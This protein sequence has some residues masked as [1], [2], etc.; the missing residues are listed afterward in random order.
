MCL[1]LRP[2]RLGTVEPHSS[3]TALWPCLHPE[4][5]DL[6]VSSHTHP[7]PDFHQS[8]DLRQNI[9]LQRASP[10]LAANSRKAELCLYS[11]DAELSPGREGKMCA[12]SPRLPGHCLCDCHLVLRNHY[13]ILW[14]KNLRFRQNKTGAEILGLLGVPPLVDLE[15][16]INPSVPTVSPHRKPQWTLAK[17]LDLCICQ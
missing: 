5:P 3:L 15:Q 12:L 6:A 16:D 10:P 7:C 14:G 1:L 4:S 11:E 17:W 9:L 13:S 8:L 2:M